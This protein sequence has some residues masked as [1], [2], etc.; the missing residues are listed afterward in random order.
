MNVSRR[1]FFL[2]AAAVA[3]NAEADERCKNDQEDDENCSDSSCNS[4]NCSN[5][6]IRHCR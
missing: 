3:A 2:A 4:K 6:S 1:S 5:E